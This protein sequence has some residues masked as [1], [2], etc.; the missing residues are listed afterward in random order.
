MTSKQD[1]IAELGD[2]QILAPDTIARS[3]VANDQVKYYFALLQS[4]RAHADHPGLPPVDL[5]AERLACQIGDDWLDEAVAGSRKNRAGVY[6]IPGGAEIL[7]R[8]RSGIDAMLDCLPDPDRDSFQARLKELEFPPLEDGAIPG[9]LIQAMTS[10]NRKAGDSLHLVVMDAHR[11]INRLQAETAVETLAGAHVHHLS[12]KGRRRV[13]AFMQGLNRT[14]PL[15]FDHQGLGT[16]ATEYEGRLLIQNDIGTTDAHVLVVRV[17]GLAVTVSYTDIHG[18]RLVFFKS[19]LEN[20]GMTWSA[21]EERES[22]RFE[23]GQYMLAS[24]RL[25]AAKEADLQA[26]LCHLGSRIVFLIDWNRMRKRLLTFIGKQQAVDVLKWA[27]DNDYGHR[28]LLE[29][30]G[31]RVLAEAVE[32]AAGPQLRYGQRLD[33][34]IGA[35]RAAGFLREALRLAS[36]GLR[37][38][39]SRRNVTD[40]IK[41]C[42]RG[43]FE[44]ERLQIFDLAAAHAAVGYDLAAALIEALA[45]LARDAGDAR[46]PKFAARAA[47]WEK[48]A[49]QML[50]EA[51]DDIRRFARPRSLQEFFEFSD[52]AID[53]LEEAAELLDLTRLTKPSPAAIQK[54]GELAGLPLLSA[55]E[56][57]KCIECAASVTRPD[58]RDD[59]DEFMAALEQLTNFEHQADDALRSFRRWLVLENT[60]QRQTM[61]LAELS[62]AL[63]TATDAH[64][65]AGQALR[66][67][68]MEEVLAG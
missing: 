48:S 12:A 47:A 36:L 10:G 18:S 53:D 50:N 26:F 14:A 30:G 61:V 15:K 43:S 33:E 25:V 31:A 19:L 62:Q 57:V 60:G 22:S 54:L 13:E 55:R 59:L 4:A 28:A 38:R 24:G 35:E 16:T 63:E 17:D 39:R 42:L 8:V 64:T 46:I 3:L 49:D 56:L 20:F 34:L 68:L 32:Y 2:R 37:Q 11:A 6:L 44:H 51:R 41:A 65:H 45:R 9:A 29:I 58:K 52:D 27:A 1:I 21:I 23:S 40:E 7:R 5:K 67:Y 66:A